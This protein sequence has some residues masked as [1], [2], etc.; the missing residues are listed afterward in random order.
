[1]PKKELRKQDPEKKTCTNR[2]WNEKNEKWKWWFEKWTFSLIYEWWG[3]GKE[4]E[5]KYIIHW[6][7]EKL[8][9]YMERPRCSNGRTETKKLWTT[10]GTM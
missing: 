8:Q 3:R 5:S 2:T 4:C 10:N 9:S 7:C 6:K 1:M